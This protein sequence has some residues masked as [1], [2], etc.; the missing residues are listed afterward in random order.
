MLQHLRIRQR[1]LLIFLSVALTGSL[2][3]LIVAGVQ[4]QNS[5]I[6]SHQQQLEISALTVSSSM[7]EPFEEYVE[8]NDTEDIRELLSRFR[9]SDSYD[10]LLLDSKYSFIFVQDTKIT[11]RLLPPRNDANTQADILLDHTDT[12]RLYVTTTILYEND[13]LGYVMVSTPTAIIH[14]EVSQQ[15]IELLFA[16]VAIVILVVMASLWLASTIS[17]PIQKLE[18]GAL[19]MADG[20]LDT[21]ITVQSQDEIG[22]LAQTFNYMAEQIDDLMKVQRSFISNAAHELRTPLMSLSLRVEALQGDTLSK[23]E[24]SNYLQDILQEIKHMTHLVTG[25]LNLA[26]IDEGR[27]QQADPVPDVSAAF[28]DIAR[29]WRIQSQQIGLTFQ[30]TIPD[31]LPAIALSQNDLRLICDNLLGNA[32]KYTNQGGIHFTVGT[33]QDK[34]NIQVKDTGIGF[35]PEQA[36]HLFDRFYRTDTARANFSGTGLGLS[37]LE[38]LVEHYNG[39]IKAHSDGTNQGS[40]FTVSLPIKKS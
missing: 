9:S 14:Q 21:R 29:H 23:Q 16:T 5:I 10:V 27:I 1:V 15:W 34:L 31:N 17:N 25:L 32:L 13:I 30:S 38:A 37:I 39:T 24:Q 40:T 11:P 4:I 7:S 33:D 2:L 36:E 12:E 20:Y 28:K 35:T 18:H 19:Q 3:Q 26:R 8:H 22:Q 6:A